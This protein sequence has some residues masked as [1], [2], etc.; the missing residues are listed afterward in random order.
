MNKIFATTYKPP[1]EQIT[2]LKQIADANRNEVGFVNHAKFTEAVINNR[3]FAVTI[4]EQIVGFVIYRHRKL[5]LQTTLSEI[6]VDKK[7]RGLGI[8]KTLIS[9]LYAE[10]VA[11]SR[12]FIQL[13]CPVGLPA[14]HFYE[15]LGFTNIACE[16]G[17]LRPLNVWRKPII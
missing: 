8:G 16:S 7:W 15:H 11:L 1:L 17:R 14:N 12:S 3:I 4:D 13:K 5:D 6:C 2:A 10:C 9:T